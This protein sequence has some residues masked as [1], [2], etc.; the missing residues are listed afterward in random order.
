MLIGVR[1]RGQPRPWL[2]TSLAHDSEA[3]MTARHQRDACITRCYETHLA[4]VNSCVSWYG[5]WRTGVVTGVVIIWCC[6]GPRCRHHRPRLN[7]SQFSLSI[8]C[9]PTAWLTARRN[10]SGVYAWLSNL[11][12]A[13]LHAFVVCQVNAF[14]SASDGQTAGNSAGIWHTVNG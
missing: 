9:E 4:E 11:C 12:K 14:L 10:C 2:C 8:F 13:Y 1:Q 6:A 7:G 3:L 5:R